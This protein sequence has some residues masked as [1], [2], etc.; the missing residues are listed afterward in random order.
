[1]KYW[2]IVTLSFV[3][4]TLVS[5]AI[6]AVPVRAAVTPN[7]P[8]FQNQWYLKR[9]K[10]PEA[11][12]IN[13]R[14][15]GTVIA[16]IDSGVQITHPDIAANLWVNAGE[17]DG[18]RKDDDGNGLVDDRNGWDFV[19]NVSDPGPKFKKGFTEAG[20]LHGTIVAGIAAGVG[21]NG[22]GITGLNWDVKI[23]PL[24]A[25]D[26]AGNGDTAAVIKAIDYA[27][28][29]GANIINLSF[30]GFSYSP[31]LRNAIQRA[32]DAGVIV[33]APAGNEQ[34]GEHGVN[35]NQRPIYPACYT[36]NRNERIVI[37]VA[38]TD[39]IDQK[40]AFSGYGHNC[41]DLSAP[42]M[43]FFSTSVYAPQKSVNGSFFNQSYD[44]YWSGT[45]V[46]VPLVSAT[47][48]LIQGANPTLSA[49]ES[50]DILLKNT[51]NIDSLNPEYIDQ[52]GSGRLNVALAVAEAADKL[53]ARKPL[54]AITPGGRTAPYVK[55]T[56]TQ[57]EAISEF[58][59]YKASFTG[60]VNVAAGDLDGD[61]I[62]E[63]VTAPANGLEADIRIFNAQGKFISHFLAYPATFRGGVN[64][65]VADTDKN[66][67]SE[68]ITVPSQGYSAEVKIFT[69]QGRLQKMFLAY[70]PSFKGG[71]TVAVGDVMGDGAVEIVTGTGKGGIPQVKVFSTVGKALSSFVVG[72]PKEATGLRVALVDMDGNSRRRQAEIV[73][74]RQS[75]S[76]LVSTFDFRGAVRRQ[77]SAYRV[78]F[79][80]DV[81]I[82]AADL[83]ADGLKEIITT[84]GPGGG[85]HV[86][87]FSRLGNVKESFYAYA[88]DFAFGVNLTPLFIKS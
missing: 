14:S 82:S 60:G 63:I 24:K 68:I 2:R 56:D 48:A 80:G 70:P 30:V 38:A 73:V 67:K 5:G 26:D 52:L 25:L 44:G 83:D 12:E 55:I 9:I 43:S 84:P 66:G 20:I 33:V 71:A 22:Q 72:S 34:S 6:F 86:R 69:P 76:P 35:L 13:S 37:G 74:S 49:E 85:P 88:T 40:A 31:N 42:G 54:L 36:G 45:S 7:D 41:I 17:I 58:L 10:A 15:R 50:V 29:K 75:G 81:K 8:Y 16:V 18:N 39:A 77:W 23:M 87:S 65:A 51:D 46:A 53:K 61:G 62:D 57:G 47:L 78:P 3:I 64:L 59:A 32:H 28:A 21:N 1:M 27:I 19:N 4:F 11:W 79:K